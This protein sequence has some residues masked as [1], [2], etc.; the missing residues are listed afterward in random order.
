MS[1]KVALMFIFEAYSGNSS[2]PF[3]TIPLDEKIVSLSEARNIANIFAIALGQNTTIKIL[4]KVVKED[5]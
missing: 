5:A 3:A 1:R 2:S 4:E